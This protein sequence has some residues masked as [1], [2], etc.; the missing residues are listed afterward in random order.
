MSIINFY[1]LVIIWILIFIFNKIRRINYVY[2]FTLFKFKILL[3][4]F[5]FDNILSFLFYN[6]IT[7]LLVYI[8]FDFKYISI[9][10]AIVLISSFKI[11]R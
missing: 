1:I 11:E 5:F 8:Y 9:Y 2:L 10:I 4:K 6:L 7:L 3:D